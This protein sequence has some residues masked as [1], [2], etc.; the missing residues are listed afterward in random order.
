MVNFYI[1]KQNTNYKIGYWANIAKIRSQD[2]SVSATP[3]PTLT[4]S[5]TATPTPTIT[6]TYT[7]T[8]SVTPSHTYYT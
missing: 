3:T 7:P 2:I 1:L 6:R 4:P 8:P 5:L